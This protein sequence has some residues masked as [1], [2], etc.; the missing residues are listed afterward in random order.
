MIEM[1]ELQQKKQQQQRHSSHNHQK[2]N[3]NPSSK[4]P[5][6]LPKDT[7]VFTKDGLKPIQKTRVGDLV[8]TSYG[9]Y[10]RVCSVYSVGQRHIMKIITKEG[11]FQCTPE[12]KMAV[13][14]NQEIVWKQAKHLKKND[15]MMT[16]RMPVVGKSFCIPDYQDRTIQTNYDTAWFFGFCMKQYFSLETMVFHADTYPIAE[17]IRSCIHQFE[18]DWNVLIN[19][20]DNQHFIIAPETIDIERF[21]VFVRGIIQ[22]NTIPECIWTAYTDYR[23]AF[24][25]GIFDASDNDISSHSKQWILEIQKL[26]YS[27]GMETMI[28]QRNCIWKLVPSTLYSKQKMKQMKGLVRQDKIQLS[29]GDKFFCYKKSHETFFHTT[30]VIYILQQDT[31]QDVWD[32]TLENEHNFYADGYLTHNLTTSNCLTPNGCL[33]TNQGFQQIKDLINKPFTIQIQGTEYKCKNGFRPVGKSNVYD[34]CLEHGVRVRVSPDHQFFT[35][36]GWK[37]VD[38]LLCPDQDSVMLSAGGV[39]R[40]DGNHE[41]NTENDGYIVGYLVGNK[42]YYYSHLPRVSVLLSKHIHPNDFGPIQKIQNIYYEYKNKS[43]KFVYCGEDLCYKQYNFSTFLFKEIA[44]KYKIF[45][46][47]GNIHIYEKGS[48]EFTI[49]FL[50]GMF[51]ASGIIYNKINDKMSIRLW[52]D[53]NVLHSVQRLLLACGIISTIK[54]KQNSHNPNGHELVIEDDINLLVFKEKI[55]FLNNE[56]KM[57]LEQF[58]PKDIKIQNYCY[59]KVVSIE[60]SMDQEELYECKF[61]TDPSFFS[62]NGVISG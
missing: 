9:K 39:E 59:S 51:D 2:S 1:K 44:Q 18:P 7:M 40:W 48:F 56:K 21:V 30:P 6:C 62:L 26:F 49:G 11:E 41:Q 60:L 14:E 27:C 46:D 37:Y 4:P 38:E 22:N 12:H 42:L 52:D 5:R 35:K 47:D 57:I 3:S 8:M 13:F 29:F 20:W 43:K 58:E 32:I 61:D 24:L 55:G 54:D 25:S 50:K 10:E 36:E 19:K 53:T 31:I 16:S 15:R 23:K 28:I 17:K 33:F 34:V 45:G